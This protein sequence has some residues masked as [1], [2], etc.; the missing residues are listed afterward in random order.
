MGVTPRRRKL[1]RPQS[2]RQS[3]CQHLRG[4]TS[5]RIILSDHDQSPPGRSQL[6]NQLVIQS[7]LESKLRACVDCKPRHITVEVCRF[8]LQH[9]APNWNAAEGD[10][11]LTLELIQKELNEDFHALKASPCSLP[12]RVLLI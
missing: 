6:A 1:A 8:K 10:E 11:T 5:F 12:L 4:A 7:Q 9:T 3:R 2:R